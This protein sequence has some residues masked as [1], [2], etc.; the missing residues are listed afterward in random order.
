MSRK[1]GLYLALFLTFISLNIFLS[2]QLYRHF[3]KGQE[4]QR[5]LGEIDESSKFIEQFDESSAPFSITTIG[6]EVNTSDARV[7]NLKVF[8][9][10][11]GSPLYD[12][13]EL[14]VNVSDSYGFDYRLLPAIAMQ[15]SSLCKFI[16]P[17]S[18]NCWG[19]GIYGDNVIRFTGYEDA[20][21]TVALGLKNEYLDKGLITA[22]LIMEKYTPSSKGSWAYGVNTFLKALE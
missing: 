13:S 18:H 5:I 11:Y 10:K 14:I 22:S 15:E 6:T 12:Y 3:Q 2:L 7:A 20:I 16:P 1:I 4:I 8:F 17:E 9:R 19:W 21:E